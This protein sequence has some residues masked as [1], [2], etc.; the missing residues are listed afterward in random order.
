VLRRPPRWLILTLLSAAIVTTYVFII[1]AGRWD[2]WS[3]WNATYNLVADGFRDGHLYLRLKPAP[4]LLTAANPYDPVMMRYWVWDAIY[5]KG[6]LFFYWGPLPAAILAVLKAAF[7]WTFEIGDQY[8]VFTFYV[9]QLVACVLLIERMARR[10]FPAV[11]LWLVVVA[12]MVLAYAHQTPF[13]VATPGIYQAAIIGA[14]AFLLLGLVFATDAVWT[15]PARQPSRWLLLGAGVL[16]GCAIATRVSVAPAISVLILVVAFLVAQPG[17]AR[18]IWWQRLRAA[19][20]LGVPVAAFVGALLIYN[21]ARFDSFFDF[22]KGKE[23][24]TMQ[25]RAGLQYLWPDLYSYFLRPMVMSCKF[26]FLTAPFNL[27]APAFPSG[28]RLPPGYN[29]DEPVAGVLQAAPWNWFL[30]VAGVFGVRGAMRVWRARP[31]PT[32]LDARG[33]AALWFPISFAIIGTVTGLPMIAMFL[34]TQRYFID[35]SVG[36]LLL[37]TWGVFALYTAVA[38]R[39]WPRRLV[40]FV[41]AG[42]AGATIVVGLLL[43]VSGYNDM[44][45]NHNPQLFQA[46]VRAFSVCGR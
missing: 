45:K 15:S 22:G 27:G 18:S 17:S 23:M 39:P 38:A 34:A 35:I 6:H 16:W 24:S 25:Y 12:V 19:L 13:I 4:E 26:P 46:M 40:T 10:L 7:G 31:Q 37:A 20:W 5:Y 3:T 14:Q 21:R 1:S 28:Y 32:A 42:I 29:L 41:I 9:L 11:P 36:L 44:F 30:A 43:G 33:R 2:T 8:F